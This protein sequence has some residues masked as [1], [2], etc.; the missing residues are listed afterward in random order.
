MTIWHD[1]LK[2]AKG[3]AVARI[4]KNYTA[5]IVA[6]DQIEAQANM[7]ADSMADD[8]VKQFQNKFKM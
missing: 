1:H 8:I 3:K 5:D 2:L 6:F 7:M 4:T